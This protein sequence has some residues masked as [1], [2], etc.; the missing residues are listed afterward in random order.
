MSRIDILLIGI[1]CIFPIAGFIRGAF[2]EFL[3]VIAFIPIY[4]AG[5]FIF[6]LSHLLSFTSLVVALALS[7]IA[8]TVIFF[9]FR[10][11]L[12]KKSILPFKSR[13]AGAGIGLIKSSL[14]LL[15][16]SLIVTT[17]AR[18]NSSIEIK[19]NIL[20]DF[21]KITTP[22]VPYGPLSKRLNDYITSKMDPDDKIQ[23]ST[24]KKSED[25]KKIE[26]MDELSDE[27]KNNEAFMEVLNNEE[28][29]NE[30]SNLN[31]EKI[32]KDPATIIKLLGNPKLKKLVSDPEN[33][34]LLKKIDYKKL[35]QELET[36][37]R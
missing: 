4:I 20:T 36:Q 18:F 31:S 22:F 35:K 1:L 5:I 32:M 16:I 17:A 24:V 21:Q 37:K 11:I 3:S 27:I 8:I 9:V 6:S 29:R 13:L 14:I 7:Y 23:K 12:E 2:K 34:K 26:S 25:Q 10:K 33:L 15:L 30:L 19:S 28:L